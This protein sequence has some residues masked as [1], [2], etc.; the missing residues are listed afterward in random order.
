MAEA[1]T[2][3]AGAAGARAVPPSERPYFIIAAG[4]GG[5]LPVD[6]P[7]QPARSIKTLLADIGDV[8]GPIPGLAG[9]AGGGQSNLAKHQAYVEAACE[10]PARGRVVFLVGQS[11][12]GRC[13]VHLTLG[14][15]EN[16]TPPG[17]TKPWP[18]K[19]PFPPEVRGMIAFGYPVFHTKQN[20]GTPLIE[21]PAGT[22]MLF[23]M[24]EK[25]DTALGSPPNM[26]LLTE[27]IARMPAH[28]T[29][30]LMRVDRTGHNPLDTPVSIRAASNERILEAVRGFVGRAS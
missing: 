14:G 17:S 12:G 25:D 13:A 9:G 11:F 16:R 2:A 3:A 29:V 30:E 23:V 4:A 21:L 15:L 6:K 20:R 8:D 24:G 7:G 28:D 22:R 27:L 18:D 26:S 1:A 5:S 19:R 10:G